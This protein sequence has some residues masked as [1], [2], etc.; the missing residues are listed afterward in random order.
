MCETVNVVINQTAVVSPS[1]YWEGYNM[2]RGRNMEF[3]SR[4]LISFHARLRKLMKQ[5][6]SASLLYC[7]GDSWEHYILTEAILVKIVMSWNWYWAKI[8]LHCIDCPI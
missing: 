6:R 4:L 7:I 2:P 5:W 1:Q 3:L 8:V